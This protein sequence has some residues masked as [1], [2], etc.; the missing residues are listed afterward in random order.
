MKTMRKLYDQC[1]EELCGVIEYSECSMMQ[2]QHDAE[3]SKMYVGMAKQEMEHAKT[4]HA[5]SQR[6]SSAKIGTEEVDP[7]LM[8]LWEEM[9]CAKLK[10]MAEAKAWLDNAQV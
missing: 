1:M 4:L 6:L 10:K 8:E 5:A 2:A 9:E 7:R 3:L